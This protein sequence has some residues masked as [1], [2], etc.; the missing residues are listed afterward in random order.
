MKRKT[1][2]EYNKIVT[3]LREEHKL[4]LEII[5]GYQAANKLNDLYIDFYNK[6]LGNI[7]PTPLDILLDGKN[8]LKEILEVYEQGLIRCERSLSFLGARIDDLCPIEL[9]RIEND[10]SDKLLFFNKINSKARIKRTLNK[11][12]QL[13]KIKAPQ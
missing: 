2:S 8:R 13:I 9:K 11:L 12:R 10:L 1:Q 4:I 3:A 5:K 7:C 6:G